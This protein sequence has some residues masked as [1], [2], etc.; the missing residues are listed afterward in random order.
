MAYLGFAEPTRVAPVGIGRHQALGFPAWALIND[1]ANAHHAL[2]LVKELERLA[3]QAKSSPGAARAGL[4]ALAVRLGRAAPHFLPTFFEQAGR[5]YLE[6]GST[7]YAATMFGKA[8]EAEDVHNLTVEPD[9]LHAVFLEF[10]FAG[11]IT[12]KAMSAYARSLLCRHSAAEAYDLFFTLCVERTK[13]GLPPYSG[14]PEDLRR[15]AKQPT[16]QCRNRTPPCSARC[17]KHR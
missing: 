3:R 17:W 7:S 8:R 2:N 16:C 4:I 15:L 6:A 1:P 14:M 9:R 12:A 5:S 10:A 11:A 13:G